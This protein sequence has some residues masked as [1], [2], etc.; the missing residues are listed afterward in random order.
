MIKN[1]LLLLGL[2]LLAHI[3]GIIIGSVFFSGTNVL[4]I[5]IYGIEDILL[6]VLAFVSAILIMLVIAHLYKGNLLYKIMDLL[7]VAAAS[8]VVFYGLGIYIGYDELVAMVMAIIFSGTKFF[9]PRIKN[10][11]AVVSSTGVAIMFAMFLTFYEAIVFLVIM[12]IYDFVAVFVTRHMV[13]LAREFGKRD[14]SFSISSQEKVREK[15]LVKTNSGKLKE[16]IGERVERLEL[17]TGDIA[18]PLAFSLI[19]FKQMLP[20]NFGAAISVFIVMTV[21]STSALALVLNYVMRKRV[22]LPAL[23]P[24]V[25]GTALGY[26]FAYLCGLIIQ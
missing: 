11:T 9:E 5:G 25:L 26:I 13:V 10:L 12:C 23:P 18:I 4:Q 8:F 17:G 20:Y 19:V 6:M 24:I 15:L 21:F 3:I 22:F 2:F 1:I 14:M 16:V 7:V